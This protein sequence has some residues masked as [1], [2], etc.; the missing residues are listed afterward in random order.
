MKYWF[1]P[2]RVFGWF[3]FYVPTSLGGWIITLMLLLIAAATF[4]FVDARSGGGSETVQN[5]APWA[6]ALML[7]FDLLCFRLGEYPSW[8]RKK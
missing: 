4:L 6:I 8:W 7:I 2:K 3:A 1:R 5:F